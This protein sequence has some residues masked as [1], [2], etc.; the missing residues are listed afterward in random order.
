M[1][2]LSEGEEILAQM[3]LEVIFLVLESVGALPA[4]RMMS[5]PFGTIEQRNINAGT[6]PFTM[7]EAKRLYDAGRGIFIFAQMSG[8]LVAYSIPE[9]DNNIPATTGDVIFGIEDP[10]TP[11]GPTASY[12]TAESDLTDI[13]E[14][15]IANI[16]H[17]TLDKTPT[18]D[19]V[20]WFQIP[21]NFDFDGDKVDFILLDLK[22]IYT[23]LVER[24]AIVTPSRKK[25]WA[26]MWTLKAFHAATGRL[27]SDVLGL[28]LYLVINRAI[29]NNDP[30]WLA[31]LNF[32][33]VPADDAY[34]DELSDQC[35]TMRE[36]IVA[37]IR[38]LG[39]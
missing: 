18:P 11:T 17:C 1:D 23:L 28:F 20:V 22:N 29:L 36:E 25:Y 14:D 30:M 6:R 38:R 2:Q 8:S 24:F 12:Y 7:T 32:D 27:Q 39:T 21:S 33:P 13:G 16:H 5:H 9:H 10:D 4:S 19:R 15:I 26:R 34:Y 31:N 3:P 37:G 35:V